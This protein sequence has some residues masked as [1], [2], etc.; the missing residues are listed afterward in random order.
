MAA[1]KTSALMV[2]ATELM[3]SERSGLHGR[4]ARKQMLA[5]PG[6]E[7]HKSRCIGG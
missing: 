6:F 7:K 4:Q 1:L 3:L 5:W 2:T